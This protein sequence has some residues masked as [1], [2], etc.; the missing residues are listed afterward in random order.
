M[1]YFSASRRLDPELSNSIRDFLETN[2]RGLFLWGLLIM[3]ELG[4]R[5]ERLTDDSI[6]LKLSSIPITL[7]DT[8]TAILLM[9]LFLGGAIFG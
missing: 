8:Y 9:P 6:A 5:D 4:K 2:A 7:A 3:Q 1:D